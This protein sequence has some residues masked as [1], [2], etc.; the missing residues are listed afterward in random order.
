MKNNLFKQLAQSLGEAGQIRRGAL[1]PGRT[2][3]VNPKNDTVKV[4]SGLG[5]S[6]SQFARLVGV[7]VNTLQNW[8]QD[9]RAPSGPAKVLLEVVAAHP[10]VLL[11]GM[12]A[13]HHRRPPSPRTT[14]RP[15]RSAVASATK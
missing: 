10:E 3:N 1:K 7:S 4:R 2:F 15:W 11:K 5:L 13:R 12:H 8:E 9:R 6:Q 14:N